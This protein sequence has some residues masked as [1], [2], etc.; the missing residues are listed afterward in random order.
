MKGSWLFSGV[1]GR[2][3]KLNSIFSHFTLTGTVYSGFNSIAAQNG[4]PFLALERRPP[5]LKLGGVQASVCAHPTNTV[6][7]PEAPSTSNENVSHTHTHRV[8]AH[9]YNECVHFK[10]SPTRG[11]L[12]FQ[13][14]SG[15]IDSDALI[16]LFLFISLSLW[17]AAIL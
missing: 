12:K 13:S 11:K 4:S 6:S 7:Q 1:E 17:L 10:L 8:A 14:S 15:P 2:S 5:A 3:G 9:K 16:L